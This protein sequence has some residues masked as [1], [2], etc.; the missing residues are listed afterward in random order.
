MVV[1]TLA[2]MAV[3]TLRI[4]KVAEATSAAAADQAVYPLSFLLSQNVN[5]DGIHSPDNVAKAVKRMPEATFSGGV[6]KKRQVRSKLFPRDDH[7]IETKIGPGR[8]DS[9]DHVV[10]DSFRPVRRDKQPGHQKGESGSGNPRVHGRR[11]DSQIGH[12]GGPG[13]PRVHDG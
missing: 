5:A 2:A 7:V 1:L 4:E 11:R 13:N 10:E 8:R 12:H 6:V 9:Q 3:A